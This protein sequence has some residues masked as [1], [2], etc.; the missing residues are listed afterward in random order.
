MSAK[1]E[2]E[3][4]W[5]LRVLPDGGHSELHLAD[6]RTDGDH[7]HG[8]LSITIGGATIPRL[9]FFGPDDVCLGTWLC[10]L[11]LASRQ[12]CSEGCSRYVFDEGEQGQPAFVFERE[13]PVVYVSI[14][15]SDLSGASGSS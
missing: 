2:L 13:G 14:E 11:A 10:E 9:G 3:Q 8:R 4:P 7:I 1:I 6:L 5:L 12:L 15:D